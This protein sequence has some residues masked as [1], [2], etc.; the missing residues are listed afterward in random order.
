MGQPKWLSALKSPATEF[1]SLDVTKLKPTDLED[2]QDV[3]YVIHMAS[4]ASPTYYRRYPLET[5]DANVWG[6][7][8]LLELFKAAKKLKGFLFFSS[9]E[10]YG[11]PDP[12]CIPIKEDYRGNVWTIGP[13]ACYDEAKRFGE[14]LCYI[15]AEKFGLP[16]TIVRPFNN[17]GPGMKLDDRRA[18][19]DFAKAVLLKQPLRIYSDGTPTRTYCYVADGIAGYLKA[20]VYDS[21]EV[22]NIGMDKPE[23][24]VSQLAAIYQEIGQEIFGHRVDIAYCVPDDKDYLTHNPRRRCPDITKAKSL[25][26]FSPVI[27]VR[28]GV[29]RFLQF[30]YQ[31]RGDGK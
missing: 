28:S 8:R 6:L 10:V 5:V 25:L 3:N 21:F 22:F 1:L 20:L 12:S 24:S 31:Y 29:R 13:R 9:S 4:I 18:P 19:A 2:H 15:Y 30:L 26:G 17:Y 14:T 7:R 23:L 27:D 11:E 16:I